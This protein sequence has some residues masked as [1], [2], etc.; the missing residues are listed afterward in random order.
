MGE[1]GV[2]S[3]TPSKYFKKLGLKNTIKNKNSPLH[4]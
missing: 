1:E 3:S 2:I 4:P